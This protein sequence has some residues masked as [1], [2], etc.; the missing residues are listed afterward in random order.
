MKANGGVLREL[1]EV[2]KTLVIIHTLESQAPVCK[3]GDANSCHAGVVRIKWDLELAILHRGLGTSIDFATPAEIARVTGLSHFNTL[4]LARKFIPPGLIFHR[5]AGSSLQ[6]DLGHLPGCPLLL[7]FCEFQ[8]PAG[9]SAPQ[10]LLP[11]QHRNVTDQHMGLSR[12]Y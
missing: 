4:G 3:N 11:D 6:P 2:L 8:G 10:D 1:Q 9:V 7:P 5:D 12:G